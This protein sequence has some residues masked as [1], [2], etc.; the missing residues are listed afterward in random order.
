MPIKT[1]T[2]NGVPYH[3]N[4]L[5][6]VFVYSSVPPIPIGT[7]NKDTKVLS[8]AEDWQSKMEDWVA[9]YRK[10]LKEETTIALEKAKQLQNAA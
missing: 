10:G 8:L 9:H 6:E 4:E 5:G 3:V 1:M 2:I 7:Y